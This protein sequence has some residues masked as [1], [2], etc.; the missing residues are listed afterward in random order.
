M[1]SRWRL[2]GWV[3]SGL[4]LAFAAVAQEERSV[5]VGFSQDT[6]ANDW[7]LAQ[8]NDLRRALARYPNVELRIT[9][10]KGSTARQISDIEDLVAGKV[11]VLVTSPRDSRAM[12][13]AIAHAYR[14]GVPV[15]LLTRQ[16]EGSEYTSFISPDDVGIGRDAARH[17]AHVLGG[18]GDVLMLEGVPTASTAIL[19]TRGFREELKRYPKLRVVGVKTGN[20]LRNDAIRGVE[21]ALHEGLHFDAIF[22]QSDSMASGARIALRGAGYDPAKVV[23]VGIDYIAEAREAIRNS[24]QSASFTYP[25][26]AAEAAQVVM[27]IAA[28]RDVPR[29]IAVPSQIVTRANVERVTPIF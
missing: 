7:R 24:E 2:F 23:I 1:L 4:T 20:Y 5:V 13:P 29:H 25:T 12:T 27:D 26:C 16:V 22:A 10:A 15:V 21:E 11:D 14:A 18:K 6:L 3:T 28:G 8:V 17:L 9:D 19:R